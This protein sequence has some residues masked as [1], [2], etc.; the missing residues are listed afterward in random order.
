MNKDN[1]R[2]AISKL[3]ICGKGKAAVAELVSAIA[4]FQIDLRAQGQVWLCASERIVLVTSKDGIVMIDETFSY[5]GSNP[6]SN[7]SNREIGFTS[8][9]PSYA[10]PFD[11][12]WVKKL[13]DSPKEY[14]AN[15]ESILAKLREEFPPRD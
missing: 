6:S 5:K 11:A 8:N 4:P 10:D 14:F 7:A 2:L 3:P 13:A 9:H 1:I 12:I 15:R